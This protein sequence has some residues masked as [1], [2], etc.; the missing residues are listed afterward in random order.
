MKEHTPNT[1]RTHNA[2]G[3]RVD[4]PVQCEACLQAW[5]CDHERQRRQIER[6]DEMVAGRDETITRLQDE[7]AELRKQEPA[8]I[9]GE[10]TL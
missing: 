7:I 5:P 10:E 6:L 2:K 9:Y 8:H 3:Q 4:E 1:P